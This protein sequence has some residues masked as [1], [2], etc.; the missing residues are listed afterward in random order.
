MTTHLFSTNPFFVC[1]FLFCFKLPPT[2]SAVSKKNEPQ[3]DKTNRMTY[4]P[5]KDSDRP[6]HLLFMESKWFKFLHVDRQDSDQTGKMP[7]LIWVFAGRTGH[8]VGFVVLQLN[9]VRIKNNADPDQTRLKCSCFC[10]AVSLESILFLWYIHPN[11]LLVSV[12]LFFGSSNTFTV[13]KWI[14]DCKIRYKY[15]ITVI[16]YW[17]SVWDAARQ[18]QQNDCAPSEDSDQPGHPPR[19]IGV[20]AVCMKKP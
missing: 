10:R 15:K 3:Q 12:N 16:F 4:V 17:L 8:L 5:S 9:I 7:R 20:F 6:G 11:I 1:L 18:N 14:K 13:Y 2:I 19:L